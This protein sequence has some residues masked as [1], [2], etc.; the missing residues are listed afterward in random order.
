MFIVQLAV[1][2]WPNGH[3]LQQDLMPPVE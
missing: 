2:V 1:P 3:Y